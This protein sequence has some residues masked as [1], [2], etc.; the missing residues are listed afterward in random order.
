MRKLKLTFIVFLF[1]F[2][3]LEAQRWD[4]ISTISTINLFCDPG[5]ITGLGGVGNIEPL[6]FEADIIPY[7]IDW[8]Q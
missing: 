3:S 1:S 7:Y 2:V 6:M 8:L 5:Y 4:S